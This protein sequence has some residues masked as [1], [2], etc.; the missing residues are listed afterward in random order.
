MQSMRIKAPIHVH[1]LQTDSR[2][3]IEAQLKKWCQ[4]L[5]DQTTTILI[6]SLKNMPNEVVFLLIYIFRS[7]FW[8]EN[9]HFRLNT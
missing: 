6:G 5:I 4:A 8:K 7:N 9:L 2:R 1:E 3:I